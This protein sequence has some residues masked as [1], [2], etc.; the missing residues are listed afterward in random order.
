MKK[1]DGYAVL[2]I[3]FQPFLSFRLKDHNVVLAAP[4]RWRFQ[5]FL[6]FY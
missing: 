5:P 2:P 3:K 6:R 4:T 1:D